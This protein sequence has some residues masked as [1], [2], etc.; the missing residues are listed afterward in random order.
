MQKPR[1]PGL[2]RLDALV[3]EWEMEASVGGQPTIRGRA[4]FEWLEGGTFLV[5][6]A[7]AEPPGKDTPSEWVEHSPFPV[8]TII[9]LDDPSQ[10]FCYA[11]ADG[12]GVCRVYEMTLDD[13]LWKIWGQ[14]GPEFF[15]RFSGTFSDDGNS[16]T[17]RWEASRDAQTW[18]TDFD[19]TYTKVR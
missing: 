12:R 19:M 14:S 7:D 3:G 10:Q 8:T 13:G 15:Q 4:A 17:A 1:N 2:E 6:H 5:Q 18:E 16:M 9:G 11:Y